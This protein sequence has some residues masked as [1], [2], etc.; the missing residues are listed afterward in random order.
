MT[1]ASATGEKNYV[2]LDCGAALADT[3]DA[4]DC[5]WMQDSLPDPQPIPS[6]EPIAGFG[7]LPEEG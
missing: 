7:P 1:D 5:P 4:C 2:C 3:G 6:L